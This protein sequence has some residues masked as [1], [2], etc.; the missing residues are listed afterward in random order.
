M[1][2][3]KAEMRLLTGTAHPQ[4]AQAIADYIG[5]PLGDATVSSFPD[6]ETFVNDYARIM[7]AVYAS[8]ALHGYCYTQLTDVEQEINGLLTYDREP[9]V[10][11]ETIRHINDQ[12][13]H[14]IR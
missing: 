4:L 14:E 10:P 6:G 7:D 12:W 9:K 1:D 5:V 11:L 8:R 13:H 2:R 3:G